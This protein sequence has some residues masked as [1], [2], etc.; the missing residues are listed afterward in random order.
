MA[1]KFAT[2]IVADA[3]VAAARAVQAQIDPI[4]SSSSLGTPLSPSGDINEPTTHWISSGHMPVAIVDGFNDAS[5]LYASLV[6]ASEA[7]GQS[8][9]AT[10]AECENIVANTDDTSEDPYVALDRLGLKI[11]SPNPDDV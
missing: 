7:A 8:P 4:E 6:A 1:Y 9:V 3:V 10:L 2:I 5:A 11:V